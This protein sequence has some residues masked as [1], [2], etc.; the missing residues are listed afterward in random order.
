MLSYQKLRGR[1]GI[2]RGDFK[3]FG[4]L[5]CWFGMV[6]V[7]CDTVLCASLAALA[8]TLVTMKSRGLAY[9]PSRSLGSISRLGGYVCGTRQ[10]FRPASMDVC[11]YF[12]RFELCLT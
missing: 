7:A 12:L 5:G 4:A 3:L 11:W 10:T 1:D 8:F 6:D 9:S 2:G